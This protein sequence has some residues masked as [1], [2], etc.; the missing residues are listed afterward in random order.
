VPGGFVSH[1]GVAGLTLGGGFGWLNRKAGLSSDN[2]VAAEVV[3]AD[4]SVRRA[5][6]SENPD[7]LWALRGG[8]GNFGVVTSFE[9]DLHPVGPLVHLGLFFYPPEQGAD[10]FRFARDFIPALPDECG[11]FLAGLSA[12]PATFVPEQHHLAPMYAVAV[13]GLGTEQAHADLV[14]PL[15][16]ALPPLFELVT[17]MPY[18]ALQ[19][20]F[21]DSAPWGTLAYEKAVYLNELSDEAIEVIVRHQPLKASPLSFLPIFALGGA[22]SRAD[23]DAT[24]FGGSRDI[25]YIVNISAACPTPELLEH[26]RAW[27]RA[28]WAD[29]APHASSVGGYVNFMSEYEENRVRAAYGPH[30]YQRLSQLKARYDPDNVFH[31]NANIPPAAT[32]G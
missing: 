17:P 24:A 5:S 8:G 15:R 28:F 3:T 31:L 27:V 2:L 9:F 29:L 11:V 6:A 30:K 10:L 32:A 13:V 22:F 14:A 12:P 16:A 4:G 7:L 18:V 19:Q 26:D 21:N 23:D 25:R 20:M 1:T